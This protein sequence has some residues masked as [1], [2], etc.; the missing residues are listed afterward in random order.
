[1]SRVF[2]ALEKAEREKEENQK[3]SSFRMFEENRAFGKEKPALRLPKRG[4]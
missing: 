1:M 4:Q 2:R 3:G